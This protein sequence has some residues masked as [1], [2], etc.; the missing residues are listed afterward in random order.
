MVKIQSLGTITDEGV[1]KAE[2]C[3]TWITLPV[4]F[5]DLNEVIQTKIKNYID[6]YNKNNHVNN[7]LD[8]TELFFTIDFGDL[9][10]IVE[11]DLSV[12]VLDRKPEDIDDYILDVPIT[13][14]DWLNIKTG[15]IYPIVENFMPANISVSN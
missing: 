3:C 2:K 11:C 7:N 12:Y 9:N 10:N 15:L 1:S 5:N 13:Y 14:Q 8:N 4:Y 6:D